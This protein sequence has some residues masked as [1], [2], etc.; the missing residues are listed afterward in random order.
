M[1]QSNSLHEGVTLYNQK[2]Y[3]DALAFFLGL[4]E[5]SSID[6]IE[7]AYY[8]GLCHAKLERYDDALLYLEQVV[9][10]GKSLDRIL[11]CRFLLAVIYAISGRRRLAN[12]ELEKLLETGYKTASVYAAIAFVSWEQKDTQKCLEYYKKSLE[13][14]EDNISALNG[15]GYVLATQDK[16]LTQ[17]LGYCKK[18]VEYSPDSGACLDSLGYV[19]YKLGLYKEAKKYF[20]KAEKK[21]PDSEDVKEHLRLLEEVEHKR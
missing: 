4:P 13:A 12:F 2:K 21:L 14:D 1:E 15:L 17:A 3:S 18:A 5:D 6:N 20:K 16:D 7:L 11:Q 8:I 10:S 9:T 19:Y